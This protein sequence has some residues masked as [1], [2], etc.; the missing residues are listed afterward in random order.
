MKILMV[1]DDKFLISLYQKRGE[2]FPDVELRTA[3]SGQE[4]LDLLKGGFTPD[5]VALDITMAGL[6]GIEVLKR[7]RAENIA[8]NAQV[9]ILSNTADDDVMNEAKSLGTSKFIFKASLLPSQIFDELMAI[10]KSA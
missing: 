4:A 8:P 5:V 10:A 3:L 1:D 6:T 9:V 2:T 7:M